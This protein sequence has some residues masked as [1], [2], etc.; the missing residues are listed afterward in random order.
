MKKTPGQ[1]SDRGLPAAGR[2][3]GRAEFG[4][5]SQVPLARTRTASVERRPA[6]GNPPVR[7]PSIEVHIE[8]LVLHGFSQA[9]RRP[10]ADAI[11]RELSSLFTQDGLPAERSF[12]IERLNGGSF[13]VAE[14]SRSESAGTGVARAIYGG[15][16]R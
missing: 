6:V 7:S 4:A 8:E 9:D 2:T 16:R 14:N 12:E 13:R 11:Q 5:T 10:I 3:S 1:A 15:L